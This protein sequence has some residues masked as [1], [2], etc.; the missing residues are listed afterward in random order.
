MLSAPFFRDVTPKEKLLGR[1]LIICAMLFARTLKHGKNL[2]SL[3]HRLN[4]PEVPKSALHFPF[5][6]IVKSATMGERFPAATYRDIIR[7]AK[8][9][10]FFF[11]RSAKGDH[12]IW[13]RS[14][15]GR[16]A[17]IPQWGNRTLKR[18]T[19]KSILDDFCIEPAEFI[20]LKK[21]KR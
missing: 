3:F 21:G 10:G 17:T 18:K 1:R 9:L 14:S 16:Y 4:F 8:K 12:E 2:P 6:L 7:V 20:R 13:R 11:F 19:V 5:L 15:D